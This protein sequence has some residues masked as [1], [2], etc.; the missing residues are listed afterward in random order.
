MKIVFL[1]LLNYIKFIWHYSLGWKRVG[2]LI[3]RKQ[4]TASWKIPLGTAK[5]QILDSTFEHYRRSPTSSRTFPIEYCVLL[6]FFWPRRVSNTTILTR[7]HDDF[8]KLKLSIIIY[9]GLSTYW[10]LHNFTHS[11]IRLKSSIWKKWFSFQ[12]CSLPELFLSL[13]KSSSN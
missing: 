3:L 9:D 13:L 8:S 6:F 4:K 12:L 5:A 7:D 2:Q 10:K 1:Y 11:A